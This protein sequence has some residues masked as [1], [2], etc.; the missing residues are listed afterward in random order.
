MVHQ[1]VHIY[2]VHGLDD[3]LMQ[4]LAN[5]YSPVLFLYVF[6]FNKNIP[7][8]SFIIS[9]PFL[10]YVFLFISNIFYI[11]YSTEV[12]GFLILSFVLLNSFNTLFIKT[13][14]L[15]KIFE[16]IK[17]FEIMIL[18]AFNLLFTGNAILSCIF[19]HFYP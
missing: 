10:L 16:S 3:I 18:I 17:S 19:Y 2:V 5:F 1:L 15:W 6:S 11:V 7:S 12:L 13:N 8:L 4:F 14:S 9:I